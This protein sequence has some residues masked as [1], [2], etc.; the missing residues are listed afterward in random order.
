VRRLARTARTRRD[1]DARSSVCR[2]CPRLVAWREQV[3]AE[4]R[5]AFAEQTYWGRPVP[6][7]GAPD[8]RVLVVGLAPA[9]HGANRTGRMFTGDRSGDWL[10]ASLHR[11]GLASQPTSV[12]AADGLT[13]RGVFISAPV[14]CAPP[15]NKPTPD[16]RDTCRPWLVR[17]VELLWPGLRVVVVLGGFGW[18]ALWPTLRGAGVALPERVPL[19]G[20]GIEA[21]VDGRTV[22]GCYHVSQQNT[23]TGRLTEPML[24]AVFTRA[25]ELA[26]LGRP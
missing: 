5:R 8:A 15:A 25:A 4:K 6:G 1:L 12:D 26:G 23:F 19:F 21:E 9:A 13:L 11:V 2:A 22:L 14:R 18:A 17:D 10:Y 16:E 7:F 3:A 24:D 20:H